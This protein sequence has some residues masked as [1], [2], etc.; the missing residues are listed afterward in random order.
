MPDP[1]DELV[2]SIHEEYM[3]ALK[4]LYDEHKDAYAP[5]R[6]SEL[7]IVDDVWARGDAVDIAIGVCEVVLL[8]PAT[9]RA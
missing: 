3:E 8:L 2:R 9:R 7:R 6:K 5:N 4:A 1:P